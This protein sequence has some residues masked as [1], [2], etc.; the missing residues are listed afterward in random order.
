MMQFSITAFSLELIT[1][2]TENKEIKIK[3]KPF[4]FIRTAHKV[5]CPV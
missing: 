4:T 1:V 3:P 5:V 2:L